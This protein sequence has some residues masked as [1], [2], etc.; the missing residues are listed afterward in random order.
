[1]MDS[2]EVCIHPT[3]KNVLYVSNRWQR[4]I[5]QR[6]PHLQDVPTNLP[7]GD[8]VTIILLSQDGRS[9]KHIR[10]VQTGADVIRGMRIS[11]NG[12]YAMVAGQEGGGLEIYEISGAK[13]DV[14]TLVTKI[15]AELGMGLKHTVWL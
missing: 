9:V 5:A 6:E 8:T 4:H 10:Y 11:E 12:R 14:W 13:G 2:A 7:P 3:I 1:M 15:S